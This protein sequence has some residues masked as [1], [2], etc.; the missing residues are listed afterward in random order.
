MTARYP[1][2]PALALALAVL[3]PQ[4]VHAQGGDIELSAF[5]PSIDSRGG[6]TVNGTSVLDPGDVAIGLITTW[7]RGLLKLENGQATYDV[8]DILS[9]TL[10]AAIGAP[11][12]KLDLEFGASLPFHVMQGDRGPDSDGGTPGN[13]NDDANFNFTGQGLGSVG[14]HAKWRPFRSKTLGLAVIGSVYLPTVTNEDAWAGAKTTRPQ[15]AVALDRTLGRI[16]V[17]A[18]AGYRF[19]PGGISTFRDEPLMPGDP[20]TMEE[21][22]AGS[23]L[24]VGAGLSV[25]VVKSK[26]ELLGEVYGAIPL[27]GDGYLPLEAIAGARFYLAKSSYLTF[28]GGTGLARG[29]AGSPDARAFLGIVFEPR[30]GDRDGDGIKDRYDACPDSPEDRDGFEDEDGCPEL[31]NDKDGIADD[32]D[33]CPLV[34]EDRDGIDDEDGCPEGEIGDRDGDGIIDDE[35]QCP[36]DPE[37]V[38]GFEDEDGCPDPDNDQDGILDVDDLC[39]DVPEDIDNFEDS[40]GCPEDDNDRDLIKDGDDACPR[41]DGQTRK[42]TAEVYNL[43]EDE[44]GCP[45]RGIVSEVDGAIEILKPIHFKYNSDV[46]DE[47]SYPILDAVAKTIL[48]SPTIGRVEIQGHTDERGSDAYN[49]D[50]SERRAASVRRYLTGVG[51]GDEQLE[52]HGYGERQPKIRRSNEAAWAKNRRVEFIILDRKS[53]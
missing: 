15:I 2:G 14:L 31:D 16:T 11:I 5:A 7:G 29:K 37:D 21:L 41:V 24:P 8:T 39:P 20:A 48:V 6:V 40:D 4:T 53:Q 28:G 30:T 33:D 51:V 12:P 22:S 34:P 43:N 47:G 38:D 36:D 26:V 27:E 23:V 50:L 42:E 17:R 44:D 45:D 10:I 19:Q 46:I 32:E 3:F 9:P 1:T 25:A 35:D 52:S 13:P 18:N 49:L